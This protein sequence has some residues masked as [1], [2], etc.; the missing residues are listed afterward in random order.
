M[1][2]YLDA[3]YR[4][5]RLLALCRA[6][7]LVSL[8]ALMST[9]LGSWYLL[10]QVPAAGQILMLRLVLFG[11]LALSAGLLLRRFFRS[12]VVVET[13]ALVPEFD[14]R[15]KTLTDAQRRAD[16]SPL[17]ELLA[18]QCQRIADSY[19]V[20]QLVPG[21]RWVTALLLALASMALLVL[22]LSPL[23]G[24][25]SGAAQRLWFG[26]FLAADAPRIVVT[27]G[28]AIVPFGTDVVIAAS[29]EAF[30]ADSMQVNARFA[31]TS[32]W[33]QADMSS[34][35]ADDYGFVFVALGEDLDYYVRSRSV[36][37]ERFRIRVADLP[38][39]QALNVSM[40]FPSWTGL[41]PQQLPDGDVRAL[42]GSVVKV[43]AQLDDPNVAALLI[44]DGATTPMQ[45]SDTGQQAEFEV[46]SDGSWYLAVLHEGEPARIS[47]LFNIE[48][49]PDAAPDIVYVWPGRDRQATAI[50]EV[51]ME[52]Q[53]SDDFGLQAVQLIYSI[54]GGDWQ[55]VA[56][57]TLE[58]QHTLAL[59]ELHAGEAE[60]LAPGDVISLYAEARD[61]Q[62]AKRSELYFVEVRPFD[63]QYRESQ[64]SGGSQGGGDDLD[65]SRRQKE[66]LTATWNLV[67]KQTDTEADADVVERE[68]AVVAMLQE[69]LREQVAV[70]ITRAGARGLEADDSVAKF[71]ES[72]ELAAA[73]MIP[74]TDYLRQLELNQAVAPEQR[75]LAHL[76][77]AEASVGEISVS[78]AEGGRGRGTVADSLSELVDLEMDRTRNRYETPQ[79]M[80]PSA[81]QQ[82]QRSEWDQLEELAARQEQ[83]ARQ[84]NRR[85]QDLASRWQQARLQRELEA[86]REAMQ[87]RR[88]SSS[89]SQQS[90]DDAI[91]SLE[92]VQQTLQRDRLDP[93]T[94]RSVARRLRQ[95]SEAL[96]NQQIQ[97]VQQ[98]IAGAREQAG[99]LLETQQQIMDRLQATEENS[100]SDA[101][102]REANPWEDYSMT[103][104]AATKRQMREELKDL[105]RNLT[106]TIARLER[107]ATAG[108]ILQRALVDLD[109]AR[110]DERLANSADAFEFGRPLFTLGH[111]EIVRDSLEQ[112]TEQL[113]QAEGEYLS[114]AAGSRDGT[115][116]ELR[117][118]RQA[119]AD[120]RSGDGVDAG[121]VAAVERQL[122]ALQSQLAEQLDE[123]AAADAA[124]Y[125]RLGLNTEDPE[126]LYRMLEASIDL[127][128]A[129]LIVPAADVVQAQERRDAGRDSSAA[130]EYFRRLSQGERR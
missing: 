123:A 23:G 28:N 8:I 35:G 128:E 90:L 56:L 84:Q 59:E 92:T 34:Y 29:A 63:R 94:S 61:H 50:E 126:A 19:P 52:F 10:S 40:Q 38:G 71:V 42:A 27:P 12:N 57:D 73:E 64:Q 112:L 121:A 98:Q 101:L 21:W 115:A 107:D 91:S 32:D 41:P 3:V 127:L 68:A 24:H 62:Q 104:D 114:Q 22:I 1:Q 65:I 70:L 111:E 103:D 26:D 79:S 7:A 80:N 6:S 11:I 93:E 45:T 119:L 118:L 2:Q 87:N 100:R 117:R 97:D 49:M 85:Q 95:A 96:Q 106:D 37:S 58:P 30:S 108:R 43:S 74:A 120:S 33:Q 17:L 5:L 55:Q 99:E 82:Q 81:R 54:N 86:I 125:Q 48:L 44:V 122:S 39:I 16:T 47:D 25:W 116:G 14:G 46:R 77:A 129:T 36:T 66:I 109:E 124:G 15:L 89:R 110:V 75:A 88:N 13:E 9:L 4:R 53:A 18:A 113:A 78:L 105:Q 20:L 130:A 51:A 60:G 67:N 83:A 76:R 31:S 69:K 72:L 102:S